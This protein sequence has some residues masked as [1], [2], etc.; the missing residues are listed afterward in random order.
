MRAAVFRGLDQPLSME[1]VADP[2]PSAND[3]EQRAK[4]GIQAEVIDSRNGCAI[5]LGDNLAVSDLNRPR[6]IVN[7]A[8]RLRNRNYRCGRR[9]TPV[10]RTE[11]TGGSGNRS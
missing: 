8:P 10:R 11:G 2:C 1:D 5:G 4:E 6:R 7:Q 9:R 3:A